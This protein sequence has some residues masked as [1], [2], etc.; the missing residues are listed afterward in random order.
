MIKREAANPFANPK[1]LPSVDDEEVSAWTTPTTEKGRAAAERNR[2]A[3]E[4][5]VQM[6]S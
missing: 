4:N 5:R 1:S 3:R 2:G 6:G